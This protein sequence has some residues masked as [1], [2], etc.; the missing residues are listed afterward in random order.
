MSLTVIALREMISRMA[1]YVCMLY[2]AIVNKMIL[3]P[4]GLSFSGTPHIR[5]GG[6]S[7]KL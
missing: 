2:M 6:E 1:F 3:V 4:D 7:T 5:V